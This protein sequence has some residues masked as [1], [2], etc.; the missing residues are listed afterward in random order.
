MQARDNE[1]DIRQLLL[2]ILN[3]ESGLSTWEIDFAE[4]LIEKV[5]AGRFITPRQRAKVEE[6]YD[7]LQGSDD[8]P[9]SDY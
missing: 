6:I 5:E 4:D 7:R 9:D 3:T 2:D 1:D 8:E